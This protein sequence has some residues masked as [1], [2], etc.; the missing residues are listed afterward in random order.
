MRGSALG[1]FYRPGNGDP[2]LFLAGLFPCLARSLG[3]FAGGLGF[4]FLRL[5]LQALGFHL[6]C[7]GFRFASRC[8]LGRALD[9]DDET[10]ID[11][12][13]LGDGRAGGLIIPA[14]D[15]ATAFFSRSARRDSRALSA[16]AS[17]A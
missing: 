10:L 6:R 13:L 9:A 5:S 16:S 14:S 3:G 11:A 17:V 2:H 1:L 15:S 7:P 12:R 8:G 4:G